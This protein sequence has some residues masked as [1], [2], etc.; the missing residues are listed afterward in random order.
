MISYFVLRNHGS[1]NIF[2]AKIFRTGTL[3][4]MTISVGEGEAGGLRPPLVAQK[5]ATF[6]QFPRRNNRK[7]GQPF[8]FRLTHSGRNVTAP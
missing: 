4:V 8:C 7:F 3:Y 2:V 5:S 6:G 1:F